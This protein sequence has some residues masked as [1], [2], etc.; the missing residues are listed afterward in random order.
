MIRIV[1]LSAT[2]PNYED[3]ATFLNVNLQTGGDLQCTWCPVVLLYKRRCIGKRTDPTHRISL[4]P[5]W[6]C[7]WELFPQQAAASRYPH[8]EGV[9][10]AVDPKTH[11]V[12]SLLGSSSV[13]GCSTSVSLYTQ[14]HTEAGSL[15]AQVQPS[16]LV[17][18]GTLGTLGTLGWQVVRHHARGWR[19]QE[20]ADALAILWQFSDSIWTMS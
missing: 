13:P 18:L 8:T 10:S 16:M 7:T 9:G 15:V 2:L 1:G 14:I 11:P 17:G 6:V 4:P 5:A 19:L 12:Y 20:R 3:V